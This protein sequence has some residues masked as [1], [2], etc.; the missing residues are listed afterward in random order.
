MGRFKAHT[1]ITSESE[2]HYRGA[3]FE[4]EV[5]AM[6][7]RSGLKPTHRQNTPDFIIEKL[8][9]GVEATMR[10]VPLARFVVEQLLITIAFL[11]FKHLFIKLTVK[12]VHDSE[13]LIL[14]PKVFSG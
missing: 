9:L 7:V 6:L 3:L 2:T 14:G 13:E 1:D 5:G 4:I 8:P 11:E 12:G 10:D